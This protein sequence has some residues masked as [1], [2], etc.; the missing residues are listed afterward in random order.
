MFEVKI[1]KGL[2]TSFPIRSYTINSVSEDMK[3][4]DNYLYLSTGVKDEND[5][6]FY[7]TVYK[8]NHADCVE[9]VPIKED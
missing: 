7:N 4:D 6:T 1:Y 3:L 5:D 8:L 2:E 9:I